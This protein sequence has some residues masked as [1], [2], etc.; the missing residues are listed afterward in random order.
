[1]I[2]FLLIL[3]LFLILDE[4]IR[5]HLYNIGFRKGDRVADRLQIAYG[6]LL[7]AI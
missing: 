7:S 6:L 1:M 4:Q 5:L 3:T 2:G